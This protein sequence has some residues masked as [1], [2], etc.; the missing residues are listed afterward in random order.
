MTTTRNKTTVI[1]RTV[2][3]SLLIGLTACKDSPEPLVTAGRIP[4]ENNNTAL[5]KVM[6]KNQLAGL[7]VRLISN[8]NEVVDY[9]GGLADIDR[10]IRISDSTIYRIA[11]ISK[12]F[13]A[14]AALQLFE[15]GKLDLQT[16]VSQ[17]LGWELRNPEFPD[18]PITLEM[19]M[20]H[21][22]GIRDGE[23]YGRFT[24]DM[25]LQRVHIRELFSPSGAYY[26]QDMFADHK[27][28]DYFSY[29]NCSWGLI[30][31][32]I[33]SVSGL[34][35]EAYC[36]EHIFKPMEMDARFDPAHLSNP[37]NL[38]VLYRY[39]DEQWVPQADDYKGI[40]PP[41]RTDSL[42]IPGTNGLLYGPQGSLRCSVN[43][44]EKIA[45]LFWNQGSY[46]DKQIIKSSSLD[47][48]SREQWRYNGNNGDTW[49]GFFLAYG[50]GLHLI[51]NTPEKDVIFPG[52]EMAGHP[53]I[54]NGLLSD[55][56]FNTKTKTAVIFVTNGSKTEYEYGKNTTFYQ[57]EE[58]VFELL[59]PLTQPKNTP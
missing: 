43:D 54:A 39:K 21:R 16:D 6:E 18:I 8:G 48:I 9:Q 11:S 20:S 45:R 24:S 36:T 5:Q 46:R 50:L 47:L 40:T 55:L 42:Y 33:E 57:P 56:Y 41:Q 26:T 17:Y 13:T 52:L 53:G 51:T 2:L 59:Y 1:F 32:I 31:S 30:A 38:A 22:S 35:L 23:G 29:T 34:T 49:D 15:Q 4:I 7:S 44:L 3:S 19:L 37:D 27:P 58:D 28:G 12:T 25:L 10:N 14:L